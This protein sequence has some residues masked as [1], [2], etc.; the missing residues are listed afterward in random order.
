MTAEVVKLVVTVAA[1]VLSVAAA[2]SVSRRAAASIVQV[3]GESTGVAGALPANGLDSGASRLSI[4][5]AITVPRF[6]GAA[7][8]DAVGC[9]SWVAVALTCDAA[10]V[11]VGDGVTAATARG[12]T[13]SLTTPTGSD[14]AVALGRAGVLEV[15]LPDAP[16]TSVAAV[17]RA[18]DEGASFSAPLRFGRLL[19]G[20]AVEVGAVNWS[21]P[22]AA[23]VRPV[24][25]RVV[26]DPAGPDDADGVAGVPVV[27]DEPVL[28]APLRIGLPGAAALV[29]DDADALLDAD[30][31]DSV[32]EPVDVEAPELGDVDPELPGSAPATPAPPKV[33]AA[34]PIAAPTKAA[35]SGDASANTLAV[36]SIPTPLT[37]RLQPVVP[38]SVRIDVL[39]SM[40]AT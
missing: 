6:S 22:A 15:W 17:A 39:A 16:D 9:G 8:V 24:A 33:T 12:V 37:G 19:V 32:D 28:A 14:C 31:V 23:L 13:V 25:G 29:P 21:G 26:C 40:C 2:P 4:A 11:M 18:G 5:V 20:D 27:A 10:A 34:S 38:R 36:P 1:A 7:V 3:T 30:C 35:T